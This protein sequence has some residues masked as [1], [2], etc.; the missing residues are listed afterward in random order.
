M[1][2]LFLALIVLS[3]T[4]VAHAQEAMPEARNEIKLNGF[5]T[6]VGIP[7][8]SYE[9]ILDEETSVGISAAVSIESDLQ[10]QW[11]ITPYYRW[12]FS[13]KAGEGLFIEGHASVFESEYDY[14]Y[15]GYPVPPPTKEIGAG[16]GF[17][18]GYKMTSSGGWVGELYA[19]AGR[20]FLA[21]RAE[22]AYPRLGFIIGRRFGS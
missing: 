14:Y 19:G 6:L 18:L 9:R 5:Y 12:F 17:A 2:R 20:N 3:I 7:E 8:L 4:G 10:W 21:D 1:K 13:K 15:W 16:G 22:P 11:G